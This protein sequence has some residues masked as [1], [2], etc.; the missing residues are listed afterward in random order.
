M[1]TIELV[2]EQIEQIVIDELKNSIRLNLVPDKD[3]DG[4]LV[5]L[6]QEM[7]DALKMVLSYFMPTKEYEQYIRTLGE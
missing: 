5:D 3:L 4:N 1:A 7:I 6:D 2:D